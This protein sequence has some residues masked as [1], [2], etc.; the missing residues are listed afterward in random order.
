VRS[1]RLALAPIVI[2]LA[3]GAAGTSQVALAGGSPPAHDGAPR[4]AGASDASGLP[5]GVPPA[6]QRPEPTLPAPS[7]WPGDE[8]FPRTSGTGRYHDGAFFWTDYLYDDYGAKGTSRD[9]DPT[10]YTRA[11]GTYSYAAGPAANNGADIFRTAVALGEGGSYWRVDWN[12]LI[13]KNVPLALFGVDTD[14]SA[15]T[16]TATWPAGAG[17]GA[18]GTDLFLG[19]SGRGAWISDASGKQRPLSDVGGSFSVDMAARSFLAFVPAG[20]VPTTSRARAR[21]IAG[22][23]DASGRA[24]APVASG[25][26]PD[27]APIY[28]VSFRALDQER[29]KLTAWFDQAQADAIGAGDVTPFSAVIDWGKLRGRT[30]EPEPVPTGY[31]N[32]WFVSATKLT[33]DQGV[34]TTTTIDLRP[35]YLGRVQPYG[36]Y[37]PSH[38]KLR[39]LPVTFVLHGLTAQHNMFAVMAPQ[40][41]EL[42][43]E[44]RHSLCLAPF[45]RGPDGWTFDEAE[46]DLWEVWN[47]AAHSFDVDPD[48]TVL[49]GYSMGGFS[50]F[51]VLMAHPDLFAGG[52][53]LAGAT[54]CGG[55]VV[56]GVT[57]LDGGPGRCATDGELITLAPT[58]RNSAVYMAHGSND[59]LALW[60]SAYDMARNLENLGYRYRFDTYLGMDH[61]EYLSLGTFPEAARY[62][63]GVTVRPTRPAVVDYRWYPNLD[64]PDLG[65][66]ATTAFWLSGLKAV[67][68]E[69]GQVAEARA[70]SS[71]IAERVPS[72]VLEAGR[73]EPDA[74]PVP[75]VVREQTWKY[76]SPTPLRNEVKATLTN[77]AAVTVDLLDAG[78]DMHQAAAVTVD[79]KDAVRVTLTGLRPGQAVSWPGGD[80]AADENGTVTAQLKPGVNAIKVEAR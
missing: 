32:R 6:A 39:D 63:A 59:E 55:Q 4:S 79:S 58:L 21:L 26:L 2:A 15:G 66:G 36:V 69:A 41:L 29:K 13:D 80:A 47:R 31:S 38:T 49:T 12:T 76:G 27:Q 56:Q 14:D 10:S 33:P 78:I 18:P 61:L 71:A 45:G 24:F 5:D 9:S 16:G 37:V 3:M 40:Y 54:K 19:L 57:T 23:A 77:V 70:V 25:A 8:A 64:R 52:A 72:P 51:K 42:I 17:V 34:N 53:V 73:F 67:H 62:L 11:A 46:A 20:V 75:A 28:N 50:T 35:N 43:C 60:T 68:G 1:K 74:Q 48:R 44:K 7:G 65:I 22:V 30:S